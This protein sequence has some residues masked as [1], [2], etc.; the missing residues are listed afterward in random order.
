MGNHTGSFHKKTETL[1][2]SKASSN[3]V[4]LRSALE[5]GG[6]CDHGLWKKEPKVSSQLPSSVESG[7]RSQRQSKFPHGQISHALSH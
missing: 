3:R 1:P 4:Q 2:S 7:S 6:F 5:Q